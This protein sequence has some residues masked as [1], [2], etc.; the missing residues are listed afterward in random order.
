SQRGEKED[1]KAARVMERIRALTTP[2][3]LDGKNRRN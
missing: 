2:V 3:K 1:L